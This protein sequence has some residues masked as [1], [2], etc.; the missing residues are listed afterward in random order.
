MEER[1]HSLPVLEMGSSSWCLRWPG[2]VTRASQNQRPLRKTQQAAGHSLHDLSPSHSDKQQ[3][4]QKNRQVDGQAD[5]R[6][7]GVTQGKMAE[8]T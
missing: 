3:G 2:K 6:T 8:S 5:G 1:A 4:R 7:D